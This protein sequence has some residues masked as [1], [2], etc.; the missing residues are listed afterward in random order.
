MW[1]A[2]V[3]DHLSDLGDSLFFTADPP[4]LDGADLNTL[5]A[6]DILDYQ[7]AG[8]QWWEINNHIGAV[9][10]DSLDHSGLHFKRDFAKARLGPRAL[11]T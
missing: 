7:A 1:D 4:S 9:M 2:A 3:E 5:S 11:R 10:F 6:Q 8:A